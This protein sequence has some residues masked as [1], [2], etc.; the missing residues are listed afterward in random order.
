V[1][2]VGETACRLNWGCGTYPEPGW[3]NS[4]IKSGPGI[5]LPADIRTGLPL[6]D[7]AIPYAVSIHALQELA[8]PDLVPAL[9]ELR[10]VLRP[11]GTLRL[12]L[13]SLE[14]AVDAFRAGDRDY[15]IIPDQDAH[16][17]GAKMITQLVWYGYSRTVFVPEFA[18]ELLQRAGFSDAYEV[19][20]GETRTAFAGIVELDNRPAESFFVEGIK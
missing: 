14:R 3:L 7:G 12:G 1:T 4:D 20:L 17:V 10:R 9:A 13:P 8:L 18:V 16:T 19:G 5:D 6:P 2:A 11:G 15:F